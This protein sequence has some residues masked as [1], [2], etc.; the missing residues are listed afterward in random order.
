MLNAVRVRIG[1]VGESEASA[2]GRRVSAWAGRHLER[3]SSHREPFTKHEP[4][5]DIPGQTDGPEHYC[6]LW[7]FD[8]DDELTVLL[9]E[10]ETELREM[11]AVDWAVLIPHECNHDEPSE[12]RPDCIPRPDEERKIGSPP[13]E[14]T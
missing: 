8:G 13:D 4:A 9:D 1:L 12:S 14:L 6:G 7:R 10:L 2:V 5:A 11:P 3:L